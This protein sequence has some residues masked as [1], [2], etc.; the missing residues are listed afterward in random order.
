MKKLLLILTC[1][2]TFNVL[3]GEY[4]L[5]IDKDDAVTA[6]TVCIDSNVGVSRMERIQHTN[7]YK[8]NLLDGYVYNVY[9]YPWIKNERG[10]K[11]DVITI[12]TKEGKEKI[13]IKKPKI[14][15]TK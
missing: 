15:V 12:S 13:R 1:L 2:T 10:P 3:G 5:K 11:S 4:T 6:Y 14:S 8:M 7:V 9:V